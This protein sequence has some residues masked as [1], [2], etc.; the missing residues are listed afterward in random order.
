[1][2]KLKLILITILLTATVIATQKT[3][4]KVL[5]RD[6]TTLTFED[7]HYTTGRRSA[8]VKALNCV[9]G[10]ASRD[11]S[12]LPKVVQCRNVGFD[13]N[14]VQW[15][16]DA[17]LDNN[18]K[19]G[20]L[21]VSC[22]GYDYPDDPYVLRGSCGLEYNLEYTK[23]GQNRGY[24]SYGYNS[25]YNSYNYQSGEGSWIGSII[26]LV[27]TV[28][29]VYAIFTACCGTNGA[30]EDENY[31]NAPRQGNQGGYPGGNPGNYPQGGYP[32]QSNPNGGFWT[33]LFAGSIM[34]N[35]FRPRYYGYG[36]GFGGYRG[37]GGG[38]GGYRG[39]YGGGS[40]F[41]FGSGTRSSSGYGGTSRR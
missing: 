41:S 29:I 13:G 8:P 4:E 18:V 27:V 17:E 12:S 37:Y 9:G 30:V 36:G 25:G 31:G 19:F 16:C 14:D 10:S 15:K 6:V 5:L 2:N 11:Y 28:V 33:G 24:G 26:T 40:G 23:N 20:R 39:G 7:G 22:E 32:H 1:M 38:Y 34:S 21:T 35:L 3:N